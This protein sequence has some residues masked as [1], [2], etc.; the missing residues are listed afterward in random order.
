MSAKEIKIR[1]ILAIFTWIIG[2]GLFSWS[3]YLIFKNDFKDI[4]TMPYSIKLLI[5]GLIGFNAAESIAKPTEKFT[6]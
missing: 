3:I 1:L 5:V 2:A 6:N 4:I